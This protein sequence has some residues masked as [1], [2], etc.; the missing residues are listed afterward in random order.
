MNPNEIEIM[1]HCHTSRATNPRRHAPAVKEAMSM[2]EAAE[3]IKPAIPESGADADYFVT[4][5]KGKKYIEMLCET[6][7]PEKVWSDPRFK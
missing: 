3:M 1:I 2:L 7:M 4:T 5:E 6:P